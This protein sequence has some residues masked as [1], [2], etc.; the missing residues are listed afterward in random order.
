MTGP[1]L[2]IPENRAGAVLTI[3]LDAV[4][5]N[6]RILLGRLNGVPSAAVVKADG[7]GLGA[8][9]VA[10]A[11]AAGGCDTFF[12]AHL[13]E[14]VRLRPLLPACAI[15]ILN[16][17]LPDAADA[18]R[19]YRLTPVLGN[20]GEIDAWKAFCGD[21]PLPCDIHVDTGMLRLGLPPDELERIADV[22]SLVAELDIAYVISHL[23]SADDADS[24]QNSAQL[25]AYRKARRVLTQGKACFAN[26]S[27]IFLGTD[28]HFDMAR[29]GVALYGVNPQPG[30]PNPMQGTV[31][32]RGRILQVREAKP[33]QT[34]GYSATYEVTGASRIATVPV[35]Y[36][37]GYLRSLSN[38][39]S[40][41]IGDHRVPLVGRVSMDLITFDVTGVPDHLCRPGAWI[42]LIGPNRPVDDV[43]EDAGTIGYEILTSLGRRYHRAYMGV[44]A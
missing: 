19:E 16:G 14:G 15:H 8:D 21:T 43:A 35:G 3:D 30:T 10:P 11:L 6:Y 36:A 9:K 13:E 40:G 34:V 41:Y 4:R 42:E 44:D 37:D 20:L 22:P 29:P 25:D 27:G 24:P 28:Y 39:A 26:S 33:G 17:F 1:E 5:A 23:A 31:T 18:Y 32:L 2:S 38:R 12:V 7:Y